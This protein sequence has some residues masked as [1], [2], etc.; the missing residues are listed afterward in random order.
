MYKGEWGPAAAVQCQGELYDQQGD[1]EYSK[2]LC[3]S[4]P[5]LKL[6]A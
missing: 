4:I 1:G 2:T 3:L 6:D 5:S